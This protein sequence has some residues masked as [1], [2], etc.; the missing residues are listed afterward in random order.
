ML[1]LTVTVKVT[2]ALIIQDTVVNK[3]PTSQGLPRILHI[4]ILSQSFVL[5]YYPKNPLVHQRRSTNY[6]TSWFMLFCCYLTKYRSTQNQL[7]SVGLQKCD[8]VPPPPPVT[9]LDMGS[10][11]VQCTDSL[12]WLA[13]I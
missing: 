1:T 6:Q 5:S 4:T 9:P 11:I 13:V 3:A 10:V 2:L 8:M 7:H 12:A